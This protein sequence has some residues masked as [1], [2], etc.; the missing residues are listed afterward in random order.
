M[1]LIEILISMSVFVLLVALGAPVFYEW[2]QNQQTRAAADGILNGLQTARIEAIHRNAAVQIV[3]S[4]PGTGWTVSEA[5]SWAQCQSGVPLTCIQ[6]RSGAEGTSN[7]V[8]TPFSGSPPAPDNTASSVTFGS[9]G[10]VTANLDGTPSI[11]QI[12]VS[13][14]QLGGSAARPMRIVVSA[15]GSIRMCDPA[16]AIP[17]TDPRHC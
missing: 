4:L 10:G 2:I 15:G 1:T 17:T 9:M 13:N 6:T 3:F 5:A 12:D 7:A 8:A 16:P 14:T 11:T